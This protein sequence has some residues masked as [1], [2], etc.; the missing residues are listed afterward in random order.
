MPTNNKGLKELWGYPLIDEKARNAISDTRSS[1]ENDFQKKTDDTLGTTDKTVPGAINEIKNNID[2]I[3]DN[4][5]SEQTDTKYDMKYKGKTIGSIN[6]ELTEDKIIGEGG[7]FNI[8]L[9]PYQKKID[10]ALTTN[11][12]TISGAINEINTQCKD[13]INENRIY[14]IKNSDWGIHSDGTNS[15]DTTDGI[16]NAIK[17]AHDNKYKQIIFE[18]GEYLI[19]VGN[20]SYNNP[21]GYIDLQS[22][23]QYDLNYSTFKIETNNQ[24]SY[25]IFNILNKD[26]IVVKNGILI[27]DR[28]THDYNGLRSDGEKSTHEFGVGIVITGGHNIQIYNNIIHDFTGDCIGIMT[29]QKYNSTTNHNDRDRNSE[30]IIIENN[31]LSHSRRQ[32][33]SIC[34]AERIYVKN[35]II[36]DIGNEEDGIAGTDPR[37][38][39]DME[40]YTDIED[41]HMCFID[42]NEFYNNNRSDIYFAS[43]CRKICVYNNTILKYSENINKYATSIGGSGAGANSY[44]E[45]EISGNTIKN[46]NISCSPKYL[47]VSNN[48]LENGSFS[49]ENY[50]LINN[51]GNEIT[52]TG[53]IIV[54]GYIKINN[55]RSSTISGNYVVNDSDTIINEAFSINNS[56]GDKMTHPTKAFFSDNTVLGNYSYAVASYTTDSTKVAIV[57]CNFET[58]YIGNA[59]FKNCNFNLTSTDNQDCLYAPFSLENCNTYYNGNSIINVWTS[60]E[61]KIQGCNFYNLDS[62]KTNV[63][64]YLTCGE[65]QPKLT[66]LNSYFY[67]CNNKEIF[68]GDISKLTLINNYFEKENSDK[69]NIH[70]ITSSSFYKNNIF[71]NYNGLSDS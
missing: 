52:A 48:R 27:G 9:T 24:I 47:I 70:N 63:P 11:N 55:V 7:S 38:G 58:K 17:Y 61:C 26:N 21:S 36:H 59:Y 5:T 69:I 53:N 28:K 71:I 16:N 46:G 30:D 25:A 32:G 65:N 8:D 18:K 23:L 50:E 39:I 6:M 40:G 43:R 29:S 42:G 12:K 14:Y 51:T 1:L 13:M 60:Y 2:T 68:S 4:F 19:H 34:S 31:D 15:K 3:G 56:M 66:V 64:I 22:N 67:N 35:N 45:V 41:I 62:T 57:N 33:I 49:F 10:N 37:F 20:S 44:C 54:N